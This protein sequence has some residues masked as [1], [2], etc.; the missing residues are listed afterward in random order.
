MKTHNISGSGQIFALLVLSQCFWLLCYRPPLSNGLLSIAAAA[1]V[2]GGRFLLAVLC[3]RR[4]IKGLAIPPVWAGLGAY[5]AIGYFS[6]TAFQLL[7]AA[8]VLFEDAFSPFLLLVV[9]LAAVW[10]AAA[11]GQEA[12]G[13]AAFI[14]LFLFLIAA[15]LLV[16][17]VLPQG[18]VL[19]LRLPEQDISD[20]GSEILRLFPWQ[21]E[22]FLLLLLTP[23]CNRPRSAALLLWVPAG[24]L[25]NSLFLLLAAL[26]LGHY[27]SLLPYPMMLLAQ[28]AGLSGRIPVYCFLLI[29]SAFF[30]LSALAVA[31]VQLGG[32]AGGR[33]KPF[34]WLLVLLSF[35][36]IV[37][38]HYTGW[39]SSA[40]YAVWALL[41]LLWLLFP[42]CMGAR[43]TEAKPPRQR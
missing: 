35:G 23:R 3:R 7:S 18:T 34:F 38:L 16:L 29:T 14:C 32:M 9:L 10:A 13:R 4:F 30:R 28:S 19:H 39:P 33:P 8:R 5:F 21:M 37:L 36:G 11:A 24:W 42:L 17:G 25:I 40:V 26:V 43:G 15:L 41:G 12:L 20:L 1:V 22:P 27:G 6:L 31:A 2:A